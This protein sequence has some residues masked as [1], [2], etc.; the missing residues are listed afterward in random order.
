MITPTIPR[1]GEERDKNDALVYGIHVYGNLYDCDP[2]LLKD[3]LYL[4]RIAKEAAEMAGAYVVST[5][6]YKF[7]INGGVSVVVIVAESHISIHT[8]PE[9]RY[10]TVDVY[11]CGSH[12]KPTTAFEYIAKSLGA[13]R[14]DVFISDRSLYGNPQGDGVKS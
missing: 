3:E 6:Y 11:T 1:Y 13:K 14:V 5:F 10:A 12:T 8:W 4:T 7:G 9:H 2:Q